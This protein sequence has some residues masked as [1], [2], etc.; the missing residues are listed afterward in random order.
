MRPG[1]VT[2][3]Q[4]EQSTPHQ[5]TLDPRDLDIAQ[6]LCPPRPGRDHVLLRDFTLVVKSFLAARGLQA[7]ISGKLRQTTLL[8][9]ATL[10]TGLIAGISSVGF[11][12][13][14]DRFWGLSVLLEQ[15]SRAFGSAADGRSS[16]HYWLVSRWVGF[17]THSRKP[18]RRRQ[19]SL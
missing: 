4:E 15:I 11:H 12:R 5:G 10:I 3:V 13:V 14:A 19:R 7:S 17:A 2:L 9:F 18:V 16:S 8:V 6:S 1:A